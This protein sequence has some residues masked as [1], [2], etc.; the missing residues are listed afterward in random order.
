M[1]TQIPTG[2]LSLVPEHRIHAA[3]VL[4]G[5]KYV[6]G[7]PILLLDGVVHANGNRAVGRV[8]ANSQAK[9]GVVPNVN[10]CEQES[11]RNQRYSGYLFHLV[12]AMRH[13]SVKSY[14]GHCL[15]VSAPLQLN[16]L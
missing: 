7:A 9:R 14:T 15:I 6:L 11:C 12:A 16:A 5:A 4:H 3:L 13:D 8:S 10:E 1:A 2:T